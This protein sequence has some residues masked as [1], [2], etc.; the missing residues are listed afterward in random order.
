MPGRSRVCLAVGAAGLAA[1]TVLAF[2]AGGY[3][4]TDR[5][6]ALAVSWVVL[7]V[8]ALASPR[9]LPRSLGGRLA[10]GGL[11]ALAVWV[12]LSITWAPIKLFAQNDLER[13]LLYATALVSAAALLRDRPLARA[14]EPALAAGTLVVIGYGLSGRL[15]PGLIDLAVS[16]SANGR[17]E[18]PL[19]YWNAMGALG[20]VGFVLSVRIAGDAA[21]H[22]PMRIAAAA[23]TVPLGVGIYLTFSRGALLAVATGLLALLLLQPTRAQARAA[24]LAVLAAGAAAVPIGLLASVRTLGGGAGTREAQGAVA[25]AV[26]AA[27]VLAAA[28]AARRWIVPDG[29]GEERVGL[30]RR[31]ERRWGASPR[32][33]RRAALIAGA[34]LALLVALALAAGVENRPSPASSATASPTRLGSLD[35]N[36]YEYWKVAARAFADHPL[37]GLGSSGFRVAWQRERPIPE[38]AADAHSLYIETFAELG[39]VGAAALAAFLAG[40]GLS[41]AAARRRHPRLVAG[42]IAA[43]AA[44]AVH[45]ALDWDWEMP[46]LSLVALLLAGAL[47]AAGDEPP[48]GDEPAAA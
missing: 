19:T 5:L 30:A 25:F 1:P 39:L 28:L 48:G 18:Q 3:F 12:G 34:A 40:L 16:R 27:V 23:A 24:A 33:G 36:R 29:R 31:I 21:R 14:V 44:F 7:A 45:A 6:W 42:W 38:P 10:I 20:A 37:I 35:S 2:F 4:T 47:I 11:A 17:L 43:L 22:A 8:A 13:L 26:L 9:P 41:G 15:L 46:A 32:R